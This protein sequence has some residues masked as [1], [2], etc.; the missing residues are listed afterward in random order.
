MISEMMMDRLDQSSVTGIVGV[1][2]ME[3]MTL[4][5]M[6]SFSPA[7]GKKAMTIWQVRY[8]LISNRIFMHHECHNQDA[9]P[10]RPKGMHFMDMPAIM[11]GIFNIM[12]SFANAKMKE[13]IVVWMLVWSW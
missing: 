12:Q 8:S 11:E 10:Q 5:H 13:R 9:Y 4:A 2:T 7:M 1:Q 3:G 6:A